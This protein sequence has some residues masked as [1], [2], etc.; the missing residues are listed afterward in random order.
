M[1]CGAGRH[2]PCSAQYADQLHDSSE[3][4]L[5]QVVVGAERIRAAIVHAVTAVLR[6]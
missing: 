3:E 1:T 4:V 5:G 2:R 6:R